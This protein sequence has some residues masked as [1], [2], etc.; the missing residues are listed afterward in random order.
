MEIKGNNLVQT[1]Y[2]SEDVIILL[3]SLTGCMKPLDTQERE[4]K[5]QSGVHYSEMLPL[6]YKPTDDYMDIYNK[7]LETMSKET[8]VGIAALGQ[9][10]YNK[11]GDRL[12]IVSL[13]RAGI[14]VGILVK[15]YIKLVYNVTVPH[16][17]IS[18]IRGKGVDVNA[19]EYIKSQ[20][21]ETGVEH[22]QFVDGWTGKGAISLQLEE[23]VKE[24]QA[25]GTGWDN[26]STDLAVLADPANIC[27]SV[28]TR[29]DFLIPSACL[30]GTVSGLVSRTILR[31]DLV[32]V[33]AGDFH[34][35]VHFKDLESEDRSIEFI[36]TVTSLLA[37]VTVNELTEAMEKAKRVSN[38]I[39]M[40]IAKSIATE[41]NIPDVN[42]IK[43]GVGETTRVLLRRVP[44]KVL[45][46]T[47][48]EFGG[49]LGMEHIIRLCTEKGIPI[50]E[51]ELGN[52]RACGIIKD[53]SADA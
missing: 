30:N 19:M 49:T 9:E 33:G 41:Y 15:R 40:D 29:Y 23:A 5:I 6:E 22:F 27:E 46:N 34:G 32:N 8:A 37:K 45:I 12:V 44:W 2:S 39:G 38:V 1:S 42:M 50:E 11:H 4:E 53:L 10:L 43:P 24:L 31:T 14:P 52:Y 18:I 28:G 20:H 17:S 48:E 3:K 21:S 25:Q 7:S 47:S 16:Y 51:H 26:L 36:D 35:G 13:A